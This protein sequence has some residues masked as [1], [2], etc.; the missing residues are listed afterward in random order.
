MV[1]SINS[2]CLRSSMRKARIELA[3][4]TDCMP[5]VDVA[6]AAQSSRFDAPKP[7]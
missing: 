5:I 7:R 4:S 3:R 2:R 6:N 1:R